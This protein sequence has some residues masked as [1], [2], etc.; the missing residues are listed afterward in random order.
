MAK[1]YG[2]FPNRYRK[3][4]ARAAAASPPRNVRIEIRG[5]YDQE[6]LSQLFQRIIARLED[7]GGL[8]VEDCALYLAPLAR[9]GDRMALKN[10]Q[11]KPLGGPRNESAGIGQIQGTAG[12]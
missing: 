9:G 11:G 4:G 1:P 5:R 6:D 10:G 7:Q 12:W 3:A 2:K 8:S